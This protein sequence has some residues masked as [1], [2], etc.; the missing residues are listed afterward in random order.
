MRFFL[1]RTEVIV[2]VKRIKQF[3]AIGQFEGSNPP[4][5]QNVITFEKT[6]S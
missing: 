2:G 4:V 5:T 6:A 3:K 1:G